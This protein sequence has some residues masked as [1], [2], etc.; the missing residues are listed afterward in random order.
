M[1]YLYPKGRFERI[2]WLTF[3]P[4]TLK[5][6][7]SGTPVIGEYSMSENLD[8]FAAE[9]EAFFNSLTKSDRMLVA[10]RDELYDGDWE[11]MIGDISNRMKGQPYLFKFVNRA[12][13][14]IQSIKKIKGFEEE[15]H[16]NLNRFLKKER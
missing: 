2:F 12:E 10:L 14:D 4:A 13:K 15:H 16:I 1:P 11:T 5:L 3:T 7:F 8:A 6:S 9:A